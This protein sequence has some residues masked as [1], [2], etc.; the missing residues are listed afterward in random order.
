MIFNRTNFVCLPQFC[1]FEPFNV[2]FEGFCQSF[3]T[4]IFHIRG[5]TEKLSIVVDAFEDLFDV[6]LML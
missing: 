1:L 6:R 2:V 5:I 3:Q 4:D